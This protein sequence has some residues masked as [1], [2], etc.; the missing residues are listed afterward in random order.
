MGGFVQYHMEPI[1]LVRTQNRT[2]AYR[3]WGWGERDISFFE[4][5]VYML[6]G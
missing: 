4:N 6:N 5:S 3:G 2:G 1:Q